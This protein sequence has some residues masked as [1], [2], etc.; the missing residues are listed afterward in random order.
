MAGKPVIMTVD[1]DPEVLRAVER[2]LRRKYGSEYR[3]IRANSADSALDALKQ[4]RARTDPV[5]LLVSDQKMPGKDGVAFLEEARVLYP[6]TKRV[7]LTAY[8]DTDAA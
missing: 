6:E 3:I 8:A 4:L 7:L 1:D 2:D 5:A